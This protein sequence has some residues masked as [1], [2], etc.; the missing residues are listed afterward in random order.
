M[1]QAQVFASEAGIKNRANFDTQ[2]SIAWV[3]KFMKR[4]GFSLRRC[5]SVCQKMPAAYKEKFLAFYRYFL[6][7]CDSWQYLLGRSDFLKLE[8]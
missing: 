6:R 1:K 8:R 5:I 7:L 2:A 3:Q 4:A